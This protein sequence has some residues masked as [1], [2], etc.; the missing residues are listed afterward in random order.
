[1]FCLLETM[2]RVICGDKPTMSMPEWRDG[3]PGSLITQ[4]SAELNPSEILSV[5]GQS[6]SSWIK[7]ISVMLFCFFEVKHP[8]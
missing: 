1:M 2:K 7:L 8:N 6:M 3:K 5:S 4:L